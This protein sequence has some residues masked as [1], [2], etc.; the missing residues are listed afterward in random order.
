MFRNYFKLA[1]R[2]LS[3]NRLFSMINVIGLSTGIA[4]TLLIAAYCWSEWRV[5][6]SLAHAGRQYMLN[7]RWKVPGIGA[8]I[9]TLGPLARALKENYP[10]LVTNYY[11][12]DGITS[13]VSF[14][15][16]HFREGIQ[17]GDSTLLNMYGFPMLHGDARTAL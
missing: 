7:S 13:N 9:T 3:R 12:F 15:D 16:K 8:S 11:R 10:N 5:N 6:R 17:L 1:V 4:L 14:G 2:H